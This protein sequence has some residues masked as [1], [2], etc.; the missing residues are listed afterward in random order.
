MFRFE[1]R[2]F[3][4]VFGRGRRLWFWLGSKFLGCISNLGV[5]EERFLFLGELGDGKTEKGVR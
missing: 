2:F 5:F 3:F 4:Y 1:L